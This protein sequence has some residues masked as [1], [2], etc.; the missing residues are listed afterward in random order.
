MEHLGL[1]LAIT[2]AALAIIVAGIGSAKAVA[3]A[4]KSGMGVLTE[5]PSKFGRLLIVQLLPGSQGLYGFIVAIMVLSNVGVLGGSYDFSWQVGLLYLVACLPVAIGGFFS[6]VHQ[7]K[8]A[9]AAVSLVAKNPGE[10]MKGVVF[11]SLVELYAIL[12]FVIS[13]VV[14]I[15]I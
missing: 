15:A 3:L 2:G 7:G 10:S 14:T 8:V 5:D 12:S 4:S 1:A 13:L 6:A 11:A 9:A